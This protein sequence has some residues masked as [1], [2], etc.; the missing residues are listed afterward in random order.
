MHPEFIKWLKQQR[1]R[2]FKHK[3]QFVAVV[4]N[5]KNIVTWDWEEVIAI[6]E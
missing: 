4:K 6:Y 1:Y 2:Y 5:E 3:H